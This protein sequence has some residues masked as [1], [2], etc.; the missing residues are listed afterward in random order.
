M[1]NKDNN[2]MKKLDGF[3]IIILLMAVAGILILIHE[4]S[5]GVDDVKKAEV[6]PVSWYRYGN[7]NKNKTTKTTATKPSSAKSTTKKSATSTTSKTSTATSSKK[8]TATLTKKSTSTKTTNS[9]STKSKKR[10]Y[11]SKTVDPSD[12]DIET[13]Y[14]D[15]KD[16][17]EDEDDAWDDFED[18]EEYWDDY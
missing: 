18:N 16:E 4:I 3:T 6:S 8:S 17:F 12:H 7:Q 13:Y 11:E 2:N 9:Y 14:E 15:Y 1:N 10:T 5:V